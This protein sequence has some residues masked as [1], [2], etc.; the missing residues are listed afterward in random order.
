MIAFRQGLNETG[1]VE[2]Q[3]VAIEYRWAEGQY[4][5]LPAL[6]A[7]LARRQV[8]VIVATGGNAPAL[9]AKAATANIPIVFVTG[10]DPVKAGLVVNLN[11]PGGSVTGVSMIYSALVPKRLE[12][13]H[14]LVA[15]VAGI[16]ALVNPNYPEADL[17]RQE[18][19]EAAKAIGQQIR[20]VN[21]GTERDID[22][23][24]AT[25]AQRRIDG[26]L[27]AND[28]FFESSRN[29]IAALAAR[30]AIPAIYSGREYVSAGGLMSYGAS[31]SDA[32]HQAGIYTGKILSGAKAADLPVMQPTRFEFVIN[33]KT[34][35][36][37]GLDLPPTLL[38][39]ADEVIE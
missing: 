33:L 37:L 13:L 3:N 27:V 28:P 5:R 16:G 4:D 11:T 39:L 24:F 26:L 38:A 17:Q 25:L 32:I 7:D 2:G 12:L 1:Y 10:G 31:V 19:Q 30:H 14:K 35:R 34:A 6:A 36:A 20:I 29:Q 23:A 8:A 21:A 9:A 18:L 15:K 22:A